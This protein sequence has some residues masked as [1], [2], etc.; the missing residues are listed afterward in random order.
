MSDSP[1][2]PVHPAAPAAGR[3]YVDASAAPP[4]SRGLVGVASDL[5]GALTGT[6][7]VL[8]LLVVNCVFAG[9]AAWF[10]MKQEEYR[11]KE[12]MASVAL[13]EKCLVPPGRP[14]DR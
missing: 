5:V 2:V 12:R 13:I 7:V 9:S 8:A 4:L 1:P 14:A 3:V 11:H 6:P 10:L